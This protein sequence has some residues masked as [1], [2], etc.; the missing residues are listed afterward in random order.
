[1]SVVGK[2]NS[3]PTSPPRTRRLFEKLCS[4]IALV[5][6]GWYLGILESRLYEYGRN[7][8]F[9][10]FTKKASLRIFRVV[11]RLTAVE[12]HSPPSSDKQ[13][14]TENDAAKANS[15]SQEPSFKETRQAEDER[16]VL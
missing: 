12:R 3:L 2:D 10:A 14:S 4:T 8:R 7:S 11:R 15:I 1:M 13:R 9:N 16:I 6:F 5:R